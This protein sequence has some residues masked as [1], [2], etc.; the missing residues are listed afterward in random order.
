[1]TN[2]LFYVS[3]I[4]L[5][6]SVAGFTQ[7][8]NITGN[9]TA[10][11]NPLPGVNVLVK[12]TTNGVSADFD[13][14]YSISVRA[15]AQT[16]VFSYIGF[17][18]QEINIDDRSTI[19]VE[20]VENAESLEEVV[21][22]G[23]G[24]QKKEDLTGAIN[25]IGS[26]DITRTPITSVDQAL[27]GQ[28]PGVFIS[29][30][31]G[32]A[33]API[34]V[35]I[36]GVGT[37]GSNQP[38]FVIDGVP[39]VQ[40]SNQSVNTS[41][42]TES[43][44]LASFNPNDIE[45]ITVLKDASAAAIYGSRAANGV[46]IVTTKRGKRG[47]GTNFSYDTYTTFAQRRK[48]YDVLNTQQYL[49]VQQELALPNFDFSEFRGSPT[50]DWQ[51][52]V[53]QTGI[54][55]NHNF[56]V[57]GGSENMNFNISAG[58]LDQK[59]ITLSQNFERYSFSANSDIKVGKVFTFGESVSVGF[60]DRLIPS[61][62]GGSTTLA[63]ALNVPFAPIFDPNAPRGYAIMD[64]SNV[65]DLA[66]AVNEPIQLVG[67]NDTGLNE[68][69]VKTKRI[70]GNVYGEAKFL[71]GLTYRISGGIDY[72]SG[73]G[74]FFQNNYFFGDNDAN[75]IQGNLLVNEQPVEL[76][77]NLSNTLTYNNTFGKHNLTLL[78]GM[79]ETYYQYEKLRAQGNNL[80]NTALLLVNAAATTTA[81]K[82]KDHWALR[83]YLGRLNY[84]FDSRYLLTFNVRR[85]ETSRFSKENRYD[86]FPSLAV[87]WNVANESFMEDNSIFSQLKLRASWGLVGNQFTGANFAYLPQVSYIPA[88]VLGSGENLVAAP[89]SLVFANSDLKWEVSEQVNVGLDVTMFKNRLNFTAEYYSKITS[90]ILV[91]VPLPAV[92]GFTFPTDVNLGEISNKGIE[93][94]LGFNDQIGDFTYNL[95]GNFSTIKN[96][97]E[98]LGGNQILANAVSTTTSR[99]IEGEP[100]GQFFGYKTDGLYQTEAELAGAPVDNLAFDSGARAPG[101]VRFVDVNGDGVI[102]E[103]DRTGIGSPIATFFYGAN[104]G[105]AC[106]GFD[107]SVFIQGVGGNDV[108][109]YTKQQLESLNSLTNKSTSVLGRWQGAG[110][111]N[112]IPRIDVNNA[113]NNDR[114][115]DRW[116]ESGAYLRL[117]NV[118]LGYSLDSE[119]LNK[120]S[121]EILSKV[122]FYVSGQN[123][124]LITN[125]SGLDPEVTRA[126]SFEK[127]ENALAAGIDDGYATP[128]ALTI[129]FG[130]R[131]TF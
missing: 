47:G 83:G 116:I 34:N 114:F 100:I 115:S 82:E 84:S 126:Q 38:L 93:L 16:L 3:L 99:T 73:D 11:G 39:V 127:G 66:N 80:N 104:V 65:G 40:S 29:N 71:E 33:A 4:T 61:E 122:R 118:E 87:G 1:M 25:T 58:Y 50:Y 129:Q 37:T 113:N 44:P 77:T 13:G 17:L 98:S 106:K 67:I 105:A 107:F 70:L 117:K 95:S 36:R 128:Q 88:Y 120:V 26:E 85:D 23:Y 52:A 124:A 74:S 97:V 78:L 21:V 48:Y 43:N 60:T 119:W 8:R 125:Y 59:G 32:D 75:K 6:L 102:D 111:S 20:M 69:R 2:K 12:G 9:V 57:N 130:T 24:T 62:P 79:E 56:G 101:D 109:N 49:D 41:S 108:Y 76:T 18:S 64:R 72:S 55:Q 46:I 121:N 30:R 22:V 123:L 31:G 28:T 112:D 54:T 86:Y 110:T 89:T 92:S 15:D 90:D 27:R 42:A 7:N 91:R 63:S 51:D 5:F 103:S 14:N 131:I 68:T 53:S 96:N 94:S 19:N 35:R 10:D 81:T 45:S